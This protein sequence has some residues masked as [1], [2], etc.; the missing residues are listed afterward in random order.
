MATNVSISTDV[1]DIIKHVETKKPMS[2]E[3]IMNT[4]AEDAK[5]KLEKPLKNNFEIPRHAEFV[6]QNPSNPMVSDA[7]CVK[8]IMN[9]VPGLTFITKLRPVTYYLDTN[10][11]S[12]INEEMSV[13]NDNPLRSRLLSGLLAQDVK[14]ISG[15]MNYDFNAITNPRNEKDYYSLDYSLF[16]VPLIK[17]VQELVIIVT[18][19]EKQIGDLEKII[20]WQFEQILNMRDNSYVNSYSRQ[21]KK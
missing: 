6:I 13:Q 8:G 1:V 15:E 5:N 20:Q 17:S 16:S 4:I 11:V 18:D 14:K 21:V 3:S 9:N 7:R 2:M 19:Q 10:K 12:E